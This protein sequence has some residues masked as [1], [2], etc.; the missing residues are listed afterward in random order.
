VLTRKETK[1]AGQHSGAASDDWAS[2]SLSSPHFPPSWHASA[3]YLSR[4]SAHSAQELQKVSC[5]SGRYTPLRSC[6]LEPDHGSDWQTLRH[7]Q[8]NGISQGDPKL[9]ATIPLPAS[10]LPRRS[11]THTPP[12]ES[13]AVDSGSG[14]R[15]HQER[16]LNGCWEAIEK[17]RLGVRTNGYPPGLHLHPFHSSELHDQRHHHRHISVRHNVCV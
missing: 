3:C 5:M 13:L 11:F 6:M 1:H 17:Q 8:V 14:L 9:S 10:T 7:T 12:W 2:T 4:F 15:G 16:S